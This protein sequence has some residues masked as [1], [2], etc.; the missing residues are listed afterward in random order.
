MEFVATAWACL[1]QG[2]TP[3]IGDP[4]WQGW[5]TVAA[6]LAALTLALAVALRPG[7]GGRGFWIMLVPLLAFLA[8]NKQLDLQ[9]AL[10]ATG[11]CMAQAQGWYEK[12][13]P[14][15]L[16][17][18]AGLLVL[19]VTV[20]AL[21][22]LALRHS[23]R[24]NGLALLGLAVLGAFVLV[25]AVGFHGVDLLIGR[26]LGGLRFNFLFETAGLVLIALNALILLSP[27]APSAIRG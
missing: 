16:T 7:T 19:T 26:D 5:V 27:R 6:Y 21:L 18:I 15:Q 14:V 10:T 13:R 8:V 3:G 17:F 23:L 9:T 4:T 25:R 20:V 24:R 1:G 12:R 11:R 22:A 2:W